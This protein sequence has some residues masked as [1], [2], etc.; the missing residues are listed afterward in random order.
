MFIIFHRLQSDGSVDTDGRFR[1]NTSSKPLPSRNQSTRVQHVFAGS[2]DPQF[3]SHSGECETCFG[4]A[5]TTVTVEG[6]AERSKRILPPTW[7]GAKPASQASFKQ[8]IDHEN[9]SV[10]DAQRGKYPL[11]SSAI[12]RS[13]DNRPGSSPDPGTA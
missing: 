8:S 12:L 6:A 11:P 4:S 9:W 10:R 7:S 13:V 5:A 2:C 1:L 3:S